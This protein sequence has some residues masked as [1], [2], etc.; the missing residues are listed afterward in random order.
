MQPINSINKAFTHSEMTDLDVRYV[1]LNRTKI[2][3]LSAEMS[4][5]ALGTF[6]VILTQ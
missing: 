1:I 3:L 2:F 4:I 5:G 6:L